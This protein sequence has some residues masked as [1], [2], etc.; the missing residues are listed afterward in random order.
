M[1]SEST[2]TPSR[3][4]VFFEIGL[5][6]IF[7]GAALLFTFA[8]GLQLATIP[9][10]RWAFIIGT[11]AVFFMGFSVSMVHY[12]RRRKHLRLRDIE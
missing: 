6:T 5:T 2:E 8:G 4:K 7:L 9:P 12:T 10:G 1:E 3:Q 11:W